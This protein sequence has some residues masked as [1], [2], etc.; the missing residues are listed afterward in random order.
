[1]A[2]TAHATAR[3]QL[4][5]YC[6]EAE[7]KRRNQNRLQNPSVAGSGCLPRIAGRLWV[8][9]V[10]SRCRFTHCLLTS[11]FSHQIPISGDGAVVIHV[12][13]LKVN[14]HS[15]S[16]R[17]QVMRLQYHENRIRLLMLYGHSHRDLALLI[18]VC[19]GGCRTLKERKAALEPSVIFSRKPEA[20]AS[21]SV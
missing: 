18:A 1:M 10:C 19:K 21:A 13:W 20:A 12:A 2:Y 15:N 17:F 11:W 5:V 9:L 4:N 7:R 16:K 6:M 3:F 14:K 8:Y